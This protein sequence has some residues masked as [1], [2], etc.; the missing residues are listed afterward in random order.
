MK[1]IAHRSAPKLC[2]ENSVS[3]LCYAAELGADMGECD[4]TLL[5]DGTYVIYHDD[6]LERLTGK[7]IALKDIGYEEMKA[8][9]AESGRNLVR[10][11]ELLAQY[12]KETPILL[13][14]KMKTLAEDFVQMIRATKIP[15]VFGA[16]SLEVV[17]T[18]SQYFPPERIL[19][20]MPGK[21]DYE[22]FYR[23]GTGN[24]RLW[25]QWLDEVTPAMVKEK[26]P[27]AEVW[28]M[29]RDAQKKNDGSVETL[30]RITAMGADGILLDDIVMALGWK[31]SR[32]A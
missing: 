13:H 30:E 3:G 8:T 20:F 27:N 18:L 6:T 31:N 14:I 23:A 16:I 19:A 25:E 7:K 32:I 26:C 2:E 4:V 22:L 11:D 24:I 10:F 21:E 1:I 15:F 29:A 28:I 9:L 12:D 5:A 17:N